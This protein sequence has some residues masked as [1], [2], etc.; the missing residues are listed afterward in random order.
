[1][2]KLE[3]VSIATFPSQLVELG[4]LLADV[5]ADIELALLCYHLVVFLI[6]EVLPT[7]WVVADDL[8]ALR[9]VLLYL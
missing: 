6:L 1:M 9:F 8:A 2:E 4:H 3:A 7:V 5:V